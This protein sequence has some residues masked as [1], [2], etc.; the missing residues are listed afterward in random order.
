MGLA[1]V[2]C[3]YAA[4]SLGVRRV[5]AVM[6]VLAGLLRLHLRTKRIEDPGV[7]DWSF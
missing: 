5:A 7:W 3:V 1:I 6:V 4:C 2:I